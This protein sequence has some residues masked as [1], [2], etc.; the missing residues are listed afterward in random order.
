[1]KRSVEIISG[2][3]FV[4]IVI[5][6]FF[7]KV[8]AVDATILLAMTFVYALSQFKT[9]QKIQTEFEDFKKANNTKL[10]QL[11]K[12]LNDTKNYMS[13]FSAGQALRK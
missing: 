7:L 12:D 8:N 6:S 5:K 13:K 11:Q 2:I 9:E 10:D 3:I 4:S 1:M